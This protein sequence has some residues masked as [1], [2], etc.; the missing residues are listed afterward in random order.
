MGGVSFNDLFLLRKVEVGGT[1]RT[2]SPTNAI[3]P[4]LISTFKRFTSRQAGHR[5]WQRS[6]H[7]H[8]IRGEA[9]YRKIWQYIDTNPQKW[10]LDRYYCAANSY[11][12]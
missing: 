6:Y 8:I 12:T 5:L 3:I 7:D 10:E 9:D 4:A 2:P 11:K 1:S